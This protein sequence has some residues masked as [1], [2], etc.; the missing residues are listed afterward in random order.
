M[1]KNKTYIFKDADVSRTS[2]RVS[3]A[4]GTARPLRDGMG[5]VCPMICGGGYVKVLRGAWETPFTSFSALDGNIPAALSEAINELSAPAVVGVVFKGGCG[6]CSS[7]GLTGARVAGGP[8]GCCWDCA[9]EARICANVF[10]DIRAC[11]S[12]CCCGTDGGATGG[13]GT[14]AGGDTMIADLR[15]ACSCET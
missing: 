7:S 13:G 10:D 14:A 9:A 8:G 11:R 5:G 3:M 2:L 4:A 15:A 6:A 1:G 12:G